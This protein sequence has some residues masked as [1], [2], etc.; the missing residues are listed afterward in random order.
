[1]NADENELA[2]ARGSRG[3]MRET[4]ADG[5]VPNGSQQENQAAGEQTDAASDTSAE[6]EADVYDATSDV[7]A[8]DAVQTDAG[9]VS[10]AASV[11]DPSAISSSASAA[12]DQIPGEAV[13]IVPDDASAS[14]VSGFPASGSSPTSAPVTSA[15]V[16]SGSVTPASATPASAAS[17]ANGNPAPRSQSASAAAQANPNPVM[18]VERQKGNVKRLAH[19][20]RERQRKP[21]RERFNAYF[22]NMTLS[23]KLV[24][25]VVI[26]VLLAECVLGLAVRQ[27]VQQYILAKTDKQLAQQ[28][29]LVYD[30][31]QQLRFSDLDRRSYSL[32]DYFL[33][34]RDADGQIIA[35]QIPTLRNGVMS[36]PNLDSVDL[37]SVSYGQ[38]FTAKATVIVPDGVTVTQS[39]M[40]SASQAWR[41]MAFQIID[42]QASGGPGGSATSP[43][44]D[45][46]ESSMPDS[47]NAADSSAGRQPQGSASTA[48]DEQVIGVAY[49]GISL[50]DMYE[51]TNMI[52]QY[53]LLAGLCTLLAAGIV[54]ALLVRNTLRP[55]KK[56][57]RTAAK[58]A[59][60][61]LSERIQPLPPNTEIGSLAMSLNTMLTQI[62]RSFKEQEETTEKMKQF[63]SD[64]SH[65]LRTPLAT[66]HGYAELYRMQRAADPDDAEANLERANVALDH[67]ETSSERMA[68]LVEDLLSLARLDEGR[69]IDLTK[70]VRMDEMIEESAED[71][72]A[73][74][75]DRT[76]K[77]G[78]VHIAGKARP[79]DEMVTSDSDEDL[80]RFEVDDSPMKPIEFTGDPM[81]LHQVLTNIIGNI[82]RY[83]PSNSPVEL[84]VGFQL[85]DTSDDLGK[86]RSDETSLKEFLNSAQM[87]DMTGDGKKFAV[88]VVSDHGPGVPAS[89]R[90]RI[91][92]RFYTGDPSRARQK[93]GTGLGMAIVQSVVKAHR[94]LICATKTPGGGLSY[95]IVL[96]VVEAEKAETETPKADDSSRPQRNQWGMG[97]KRAK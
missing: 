71:L 54:S 46:S 75:P 1:M 23:F 77:L 11:A 72:H 61:D 15:P 37:S 41:V 56:M 24:S 33:Q 91:F 66:I 40:E 47:S 80:V 79:I 49:I 8:A 2:A 19:A 28:A 25:L 12:Q 81:R 94:G 68:A 44:S 32:T 38:A 63:V 58:I 76:V 60:G 62:E 96:P 89:Q 50:R 31:Y 39:E 45:G 64:A 5:N 30:N 67:I 48:D 13:S 88:V 34:I 53:F 90:S 29:Q 27:L 84:G 35:S 73:L 21:L 14:I 26:V 85:A 52:V 86:K 22:D 57:E 16:T 20:S 3:S 51:T 65:E 17:S 78:G 82:H 69:G 42:V 4:E 87:S 6:S 10:S 95:T 97:R 9:S 83:T 18:A 43:E 92:E 70:K 59:A 7:T 55:L 74:D 93:G 36:E